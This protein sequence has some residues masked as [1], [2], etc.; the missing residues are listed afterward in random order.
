MFMYSALLC[1]R[2]GDYDQ[3]PVAGR[4]NFDTPVTLIDWQR[5]FSSSVY[6]LARI[7]FANSVCALSASSC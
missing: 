2:G 4:R 1:M 5:L 3:Q 7:R 6:S